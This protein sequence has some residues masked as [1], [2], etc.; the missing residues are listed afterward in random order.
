[1]KQLGAPSHVST[2]S[3]AGSGISGSIGS[4]SR[5]AL[6]GASWVLL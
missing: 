5:L 4:I 6:S 1:M 3:S 2:N